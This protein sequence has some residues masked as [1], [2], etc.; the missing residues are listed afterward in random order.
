[1]TISKIEREVLDN[2]HKLR[3]RFQN[4]EIDQDEM[5]EAIYEELD[6]LDK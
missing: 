4:W 1:M 2:I 5:T 3:E 6:K